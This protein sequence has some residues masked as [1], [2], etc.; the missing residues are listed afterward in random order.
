MDA[1]GKP[2]L[3]WAEKDGENLLI[4]YEQKKDMKD[5]SVIVV[6]RLSNLVE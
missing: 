3:S 5:N 2:I 1:K 4:A 6:E